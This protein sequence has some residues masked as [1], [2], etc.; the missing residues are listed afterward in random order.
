MKTNFEKLRLKELL[1]FCCS[2]MLKYRMKTRISAKE[3]RFE[4]VSVNS[5]LAIIDEVK[6]IIISFP[7]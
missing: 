2:A 3:I 7:Q 6:N 4:S 5:K 1:C